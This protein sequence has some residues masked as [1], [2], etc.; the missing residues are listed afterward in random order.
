MLCIVII[1][2]L[3]TNAFQYESNNTSIYLER[4]NLCICLRL[5]LLVLCSSLVPFHKQL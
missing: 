2:L 1:F 4:E 5:G 3:L